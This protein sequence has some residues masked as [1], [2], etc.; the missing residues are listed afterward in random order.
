M[1]SIAGV[2]AG[3]NSSPVPFP[4]AFGSAIS[5]VIMDDKLVSLPLIVYTNTDNEQTK[6]E[7]IDLFERLLHAGSE[8][9]YDRLFEW[10]RR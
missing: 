10:D 8:K 6:M 9:A 3:V 1:L 2:E 4:I 7:A 5:R